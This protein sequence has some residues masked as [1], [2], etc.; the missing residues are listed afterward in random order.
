MLSHLSIQNFA[1]IKEL[2][3]DLHPGLNIITGET[4]AG[5]SVIIQAV[6]MALGSRADTDFIRSGED[7]AVVTLT[8][9]EDPALP[10]KLAGI[11]APEDIPVVLKREISAQSRSL[12]RINGSIVPLSQLSSICKG[13][14]DIHGQYDHQS[15]LDPENH[16]EILDLF[17]DDRLQQAKQQTSASYQ[18]FTKAA[19]ELAALRKNLK[20]AQRQRDL[21]SMEV[22]D[23]EA[24]RLQPEEDILLE[25]QIAVMQHSEQ[26]YQNLSASYQSL[27]SGE[28]NAL[29]AI[30][31]SVSR[32]QSV[33]GFSA[34]I[35]ALTEE[36]SDLYYRIDDL[37]NG[38]R[39]MIDRVSFSP[40]QLDDA[41]ER[42]EQINRIK[43][44]FGGTVEAALSYAENAKAQ[45]EDL[46]NSD[47]K[48][49]SLEQAFVTNKNQYDSAAAR[50]TELRRQT[51]DLLCRNVN[52][53]LTELNFKNAIFDV[54][55]RT[56]TPSENGSDL[57]EFLISA[58]KGEELRPLAKVASGGE[59]SRIMLALKRIIGDLDGIPTMIFD[60]IDTGISGATA[61]IVGEKLRSIAKSHQIICIT[62]L[63]QIAAMGDHHYLIKKMSDDSST[64]TTVVPLSQEERLE[65][66]ARLLSG[67]EITDSARAQAAELL[68]QSR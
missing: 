56:G 12:C 35:K 46:E 57:V 2:D 3:L 44:K 59:L 42:L 31:D 30:G 4:G 66:L 65:E 38:L 16:L 15:L 47:E 21:L 37:N 51:A 22:A 32:L 33:E 41:I 62:H 40:A 17:G 63:P 11:G 54:S 58:N 26:I 24:A 39:H 20:E 9:E 53:E 67:T 50:L 5:K 43:R 34:D 1:V 36:L 23:I 19:A 60:E 13:I 25:E 10:E 45:L 8:V 68:Q 28:T 49:R 18:A 14:A 6:S 27:F 7:K 48:I 55:F 64:R 52:R 61:G 29:D